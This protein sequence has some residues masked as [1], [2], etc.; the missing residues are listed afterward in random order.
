MDDESL[1]RAS[2]MGNESSLSW[3][4]YR[5]FSIKPSCS[6]FLIFVEAEDLVSLHSANFS[7]H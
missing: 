6:V 2:I 1:Q 3:G 5:F 4:N 7:M